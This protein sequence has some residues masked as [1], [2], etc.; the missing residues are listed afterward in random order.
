MGKK[1]ENQPPSL[2][3]NLDLFAAGTAEDAGAR[4][5]PQSGRV[6][7]ETKKSKGSSMT[8]GGGAASTLLTHPP[9]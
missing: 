5:P 6:E 1:E 9:C 2:F 4:R 3:D 8:S 7:G